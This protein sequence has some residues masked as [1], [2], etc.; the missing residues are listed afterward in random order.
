LQEGGMKA[1]K[2]EA[3]EFCRLCREGMLFE[4]QEWI[5]AGRPIP[6]G[7]KP[8]YAPLLLAAGKGFHSLVMVLL[9]QGFGCTQAGLDD[10]LAAAV[11]GGHCET[12][13]LL[14]SRGATI[15]RIDARAVFKA[16]DVEILSVCTLA[17][18]DL[19]T[20]T[21]LAVALIN[22]SDAAV[23][24][25]ERWH[26]KSKAV[27]DQG[28][29]ALIR[30]VEDSDER[31]VRRLLKAGANVRRRVPKLGPCY[32]V[33]YPTTAL[34]EG[35][36]RATFRVLLLLGVRK[37]DDIGALLQAA[38]FDFD[39]VKIKHLIKR[40]GVLNDKNGGC[41]VLQECLSK[42]GFFYHLDL[43]ARARAA[44]DAVV[45]LADMGARWVPD[46]EELRDV[47]CGLRHAGTDVWIEVAA[48]LSKGGAADRA[49]VRRLFGTP[50]MKRRLRGWWTG[51]MEAALAH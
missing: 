28:A 23:R 29:M 38:C 27:G 45:Q 48:V 4:V 11:H 43:F 8:A 47:R 14:L 20:G 50:A 31:C 46:A 49:T 9:G 35:A 16:P 33:G 15:A 7:A 39:M 37:T 40:R 2:R 1:E 36:R 19:C 22:Q 10:A 34:E 5:R 41:S 26:S 13:R 17:G 12:A 44:L 42:M 32:E 6:T 24:F 51:K 21:P 18:V 3:R 25:L 30:A